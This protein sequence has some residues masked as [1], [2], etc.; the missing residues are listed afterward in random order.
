[1]DPTLIENVQRGVAAQGETSNNLHQQVI[2][3]KPVWD[4]TCAQLL[5]PL[6][7][8]A[9]AADMKTVLQTP[10]ALDA[11]I[12]VLKGKDE[13]TKQ[14]MLA[15]LYE[16]IRED[17]SAYTV[18]DDALKLE[19]DIYS[20]FLNLV[21]AKGDGFYTADKAAWLLSGIMSSSS[22][23][24]QN[25]Q[26]E[27]LVS[28][29][30]S[31]CS[32]VGFLDAVTNL[33]KASQFRSLVWKRD[34]VA[35]KVLE[36]DVKGPS[37]LVYKA[38]FSMWLVS[39]DADLMSALKEQ[40]AVAKLKEILTSSSRVEKVVR[41]TLTAL[42]NFLKNKSFCEEIVEGHV[43]EAVQ[44]LE[45]EKWKDAELYEQIREMVALISHEV[46]EFSNFDRYERELHTGKLSW[47]FVHTSKFWAENVMKF[48][49]NDYRPLH[50]L[51]A[52]LNSDDNTTL[53]V[54][55]HD[56]GEFVGL[57]PLG[58]RKIAELSV[59]ARVMEL[60]GSTGD[61]KREVRREALL[62][63]QK[64]MLNKW[65]DMDKPKV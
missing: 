44:A 52:C 47:G 27:S 37:S 31:N 57:H 30:M 18:F 19:V 36:V 24:F 61:D 50:K 45:F 22:S 41:I 15:F 21:Q 39:F 46:V 65:H 28:A 58:K 3:F 8:K 12:G 33:L 43:L 35:P 51:A 29:A 40:H 56:L 32:A 7:A 54:A 42:G 9:P 59:K 16:V 49:Q 60:M 2:D 26:V 53:A 13:K 64:I 5:S 38:V 1:M 55:C 63:C 6:D 17:S 20:T 4:A 25:S 14:W 23:Y 62:C 10:Y 34:G 48:E 11:C